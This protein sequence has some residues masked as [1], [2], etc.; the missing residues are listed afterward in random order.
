MRV[1]FLSASYLPESVGGVEL[2]IEGLCR[3]LREAGHEAVVLARTGAP[4]VGHLELAQDEVNA[5]PVWRLGNDFSDAT[6]LRKLYAHEGID[7]AVMRAVQE[8][9][10]DLVHIHHLT[11]LST[12]VIAALAEARLPTVMTLH[13]FWMGCPRGQRITAGLELCPEIRLAKCVPC[14][15]ELWPHLLGVNPSPE[16]P[17]DEKDAHD[18]ALLEEYHATIQRMLSEVSAL[19]TPSAFMARMYE[20]YGVARGRIR[21]LPNGL[22]TARFAGMGPRSSHEGPLRVGFLGSVLPSKGVHLLID[23]WRRLGDPLG[24]A[25][26]IW[27]EALPF[28]ND[29]SYGERLE[30]MCAGDASAVQLHGRYENHQVPALLAELDVLVVPSIWYEAFAL[31]I[32]EA[33]LAGVPVIAANHGAMAEAVQHGVTGLLFEAGDSASLAACLRQLVDDAE[34]RRRLSEAARLTVRDEAETAGELLALYD[35]LLETRA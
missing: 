26:H 15:R 13:D 29:R 28:H 25:L 24:I 12:T 30:A 23:A 4:E 19:V 14:L 20:A 5:V 22:P 17:A 16:A 3:A 35:S 34:L 33:F 10:P 27:G 21:V 11:C 8:I 9:E 32:R 31:T 18:R 6:E 1:L 7:A 2:H